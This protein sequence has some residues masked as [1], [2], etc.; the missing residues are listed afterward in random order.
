[1][2]YCGKA[3]SLGVKQA[4]VKVGKWSELTLTKSPKIT[5]LAVGHEGLHA[6]LLT[7]DGSVFFVGKRFM[8]AYFKAFYWS[9]FTFKHIS[10]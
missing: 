2:F 7:E 3:A 9:G 1:M 6:I 5:H 8:F 4:S 10:I